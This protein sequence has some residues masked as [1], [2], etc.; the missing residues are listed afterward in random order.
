MKNFICIKVDREERPDVDQVY[1]DAKSADGTN[2]WLVTTFF[3]M[4]DQKPFM[5]VPTS[6]K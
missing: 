5:E 3:L 6:L 1:M 2:W 4:P